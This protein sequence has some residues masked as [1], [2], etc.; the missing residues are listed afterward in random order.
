[1]RAPAWE[2]GGKLSNSVFA[3]A[4]DLEP[5]ANV[6]ATEIF[7]NAGQVC[8]AGSQ[9]L[10]ERGILVRLST[11][12]T[13]LSRA[14]RMVA[15]LR[16]GVVHVNTYGNADSPV[17]L[18]AWNNPVTGM[19]NRLMHWISIKTSKPLGSRYDRNPA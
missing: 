13:N 3:D 15:G 18:G 19:T 5:A 1:M 8:F 16:A 14:H 11:Q 10:V 12:K 2:R 4:P 9:R 17:P 6:S 7:C